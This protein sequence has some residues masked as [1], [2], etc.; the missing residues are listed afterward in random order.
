MMSSELGIHTSPSS[1]LH[2]PTSDG[3][4]FWAASAAATSMTF[5]CIYWMHF[6]I[7][8]MHRL[9]AEPCVLHRK[10]RIPRI[11]FPKRT[12]QQIILPP[13]LNPQVEST[14]PRH[15]TKSICKS[16]IRGGRSRFTV[17]STHRS[18]TSLSG[19]IGQILLFL[20]QTVASSQHS[21][22]QHEQDLVHLTDRGRP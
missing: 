18:R 13:H 21:L 8:R 7:E 14:M 12:T 10:P 15:P 19:E 5:L 2:R 20:E 17:C 9:D 3:V 4:L 22:L 11:Y 1:W 6:G 16:H